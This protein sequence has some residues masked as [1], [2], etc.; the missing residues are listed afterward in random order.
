MRESA[1][2]LTLPLDGGREERSPFGHVRYQRVDLRQW[3]DRH[4]GLPR[5]DYS[6]SFNSCDQ[7]GPNPSSPPSPDP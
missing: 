7:G 3:T 5:K 4:L 2:G 6:P 1:P